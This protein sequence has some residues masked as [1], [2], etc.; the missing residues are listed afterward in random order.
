MYIQDGCFTLREQDPGLAFGAH[1]AV[2]AQFGPGRGDCLALIYTARSVEG[3]G[4]GHYIIRLEMGEARRWLLG[5]HYSLEK[6]KII[7]NNL[8]FVL[9]SWNRNS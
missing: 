2:L 9:R 7:I 3:S 5:N 4:F 1:L 8:E 6:R